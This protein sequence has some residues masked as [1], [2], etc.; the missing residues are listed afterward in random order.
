MQRLITTALDEEITPNESLVLL[1]EWCRIYGEGKTT[2]DKA[3]VIAYHWDDRNKLSG[4]F[5]YLQS[6]TKRLI[7]E[8]TVVLNA[9][10]N[11]SHSARYWELLLGFWLNMFCSVVFDRWSL[12]KTAVESHSKLFVSKRQFNIDNFVPNDTSHAVEQFVQDSWNHVIFETLISQKFPEIKLLSTGEAL[13]DVMRNT[14]TGDAENACNSRSNRRI[15]NRFNSLLEYLSARNRYL[16]C[17]IGVGLREYLALSLRLGCVPHITKFSRV[18][19]FAYSE[20]K[21]AWAISP[22][23]S[24]DSGFESIVRLLIPKFI[25]KVFVEGYDKVRERVNLR[26]KKQ[27]LSVIFTSNSHFFDEEF[28]FFSAE[29]RE[30]GTLLVIG[31]HGGGAFHKFNGATSYEL[32][33]SDLYLTTGSGNCID[34]PKVVDVGRLNNNLKIERWNPNGCGLFV[35]VAMPRYSF[36]LRAMPIAGQ[37][38]QYFNDQFRLYN[39]LGEKIRKEI[40]LRLFPSDYEWHQKGRWLDKFPMASFDDMLSRFN[41]Q[42]SKSRILISTYN[43]TTYNES[44]A[45]NIPTVIYWNPAYWE[46]DET[47]QS[48]FNEL[49]SVG[50]Y[51]TCPESAAKHLIEIWDNVSLWWYDNKVQSARHS[52]CLSYAHIPKNVSSRLAQVLRGAAGMSN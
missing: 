45:A 34:N 47:A 12:L 16:F 4:D 38:L 8:L 31:Q 30:N 32:S 10:H 18:E 13:L 41:G 7:G 46:I 14:H 22:S 15:L 9:I 49:K 24:A 20:L 6:L 28:K 48:Y 23:S 1:G 11:T 27:K 5:C 39:L 26:Y 44:L 19:Q 33:V 25:P 52:Y 36:D 40:R 17:D 43:A 37:M 3:Q 29:K 2:R 50:I 35:S 42:L 21:R 51:H